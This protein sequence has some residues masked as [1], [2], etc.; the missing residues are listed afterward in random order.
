[1]S[2]IF[3]TFGV[4]WHLLLVSA[5]NF[6]ILILGLWY[7]LYKPLG[8]MLEERR[9]KVAQGVKDAQKAE[10]E[11]HTIEAARASKLADAGREADQVIAA[12][13]AAGTSKERE[14]IS[15][16]EAAAARILE[17]GER[18]AK[19]L[20]SQAITESKEEVAKMIVLGVE[21]ML[22]EKRT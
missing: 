3:T 17:E 16:G 2:A 7:F 6:G 9:S 11:L 18:Q 20:K 5:V 19:E 13:R 14:L 15:G 21:K 1:M 12:A 22:K 10:E 4:D 8:R